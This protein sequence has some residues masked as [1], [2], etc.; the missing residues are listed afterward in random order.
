MIGNACQLIVNIQTAV[1][2]MKRI[3]YDVVASGRDWL[4]RCEGRDL[5]RYP[6]LA[7]AEAAA[8]D[9]ARTDRNRGMHA[10][11]TTPQQGPPANP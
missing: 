1:S 5:H 2:P 8:F 7:E 11:V 9:M 6:T 4:I 3:H 10:Q